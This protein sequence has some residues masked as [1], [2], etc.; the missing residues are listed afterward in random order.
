MNKRCRS[1]VILGVWIQRNIKYHRWGKLRKILFDSSYCPL[2]FKH[3][4]STIIMSQAFSQSLKLDLY[5]K[6]YKIAFT[7]HYF[8]NMFF[9][10]L[11]LHSSH[12][13]KEIPDCGNQVRSDW[14]GNLR[15]DNTEPY[16]SFSWVNTEPSVQFRKANTDPSVQFRKANTDPSLQF[17]WGHTEFIFWKML[18]KNLHESVRP[19]SHL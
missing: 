15:W 13:T 16:E 11:F 1:R 14:V 3:Y 12:G 6:I 7:H 10:L 18:G 19:L 4:S 9:L 8:S 17:K 5:I 2:N